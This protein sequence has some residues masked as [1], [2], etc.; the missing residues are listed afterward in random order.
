MVILAVLLVITLLG[1]AAEVNAGLWLAD[2]KERKSM[3]LR[4]TKQKA[5]LA[6]AGLRLN[7]PAPRVE[8]ARKYPSRAETRRE[9]RRIQKE[10]DACQVC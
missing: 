5:D 8:E 7:T 9:I 3:Q 1:I 4:T 10:M 2:R 6:R